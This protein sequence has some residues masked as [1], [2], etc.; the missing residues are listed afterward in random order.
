MRMGDRLDITVDLRRVGR[1]SIRFDYRVVGPDGT[2]RATASLVHVFVT[3]SDFRPR[4]IPEGFLAALRKA[5]LQVA[6]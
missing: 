2:V 6:D 4:A 1:T 3:L 5:G